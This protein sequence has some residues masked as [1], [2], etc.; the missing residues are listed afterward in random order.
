MPQPNSTIFATAGSYCSGR[1][2]PNTPSQTISAKGRLKV[3]AVRTWLAHDDPSLFATLPRTNNWI[4]SATNQTRPG[5]GC[6]RNTTK[7]MT[8]GKTEQYRDERL[9]IR[10]EG[11]AA[12]LLEG[13][14]R[15]HVELL[16]QLQRVQSI[17]T[18]LPNQRKSNLINLISFHLSLHPL[19]CPW[20]LK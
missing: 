14:R 9:P 6:V 19:S 20:S 1:V 8:K 17:R 18:H 12:L 11:S 7:G 13:Q 5:L 3:E 4:P 15:R 16:Q 2:V 10:T